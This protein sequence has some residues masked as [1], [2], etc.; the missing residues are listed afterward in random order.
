MAT[1]FLPA[2][3]AKTDANLKIEIFKILRQ[4]KIFDAL[5]KFP[6]R[7]VFV[8]D[9]GS[10][11]V[12]GLNEHERLNCFAHLLNNLTKKACDVINNNG[13]ILETCRYVVRYIK[14]IGLNEFENGA[15]KMAVET[16]WDSNFDMLESL[17][18]N[19]NEVLDILEKRNA[20]EKLNDLQ[21]S[22]IDAVVSFLRPMK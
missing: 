13:G 8:T 18:K 4:F 20:T 3:I 15:L 19:W 14:R 1:T 21:K 22:S 11:L 17:S 6:K 12:S 16:R 9:R 2:E 10:N 5:F 7:L